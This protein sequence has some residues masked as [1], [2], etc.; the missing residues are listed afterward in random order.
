MK[1][2]KL[3][4]LIL[5]LAYTLPLLARVEFEDLAVEVTGIEV[6]TGNIL[7]SL[8]DNKSGFPTDR[9]QAIK[10]FTIPARK[11][12]VALNITGLS[13]NKDYAVAVCHDANG[14]E[15]CDTNFLGIPK[16][17]VGVSNNA[18]GRFGPPSFEDSKFVFTWGK[19]ISI[20]V[21]Y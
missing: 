6:E 15:E 5:F 18:K 17:G 14:N 7:V 3:L 20:Q 9:K 16:E 4:V 11:N 21:K 1:H 12:R 13:Q 19:R 10:E 8:Y 2:H